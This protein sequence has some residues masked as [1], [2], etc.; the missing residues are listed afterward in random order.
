MAPLK[1][2]QLFPDVHF[3]EPGKGRSRNESSGGLVCGI[4]LLI[5]VC[6]YVNVYHVSSQFLLTALYACRTLVLM[7]ACSLSRVYDN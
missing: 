3:W 7:E 6:T 4:S 2:L 5:V 1:L